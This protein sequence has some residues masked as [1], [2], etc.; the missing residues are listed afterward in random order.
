MNAALRVLAAGAVLAL[1]AVPAAAQSRVEEPGTIGLTAGGAYGMIT[2]QSRYG[3]D[4]TDGA[5]I[6]V[7]LRYVL[8]P[9][10]S[11]GATFA[12]QAYQAGTTAAAEGTDKVQMTNVLLDFYYYRDRNT[13]ASQYLVMGLGFY[14]PE[15][16][17]S[18]QEI[19]FPGENALLSVGAGAE[20]FIRE[21]WGLELSAR[22]LG[23]FGRGFTPQELADTTT[24]LTDSKVAL[25]LHAQVGLIYYL[26]R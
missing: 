1:A 11:T 10:W 12:S 17:D 21:N 13:D 9:H 6:T 25:G 3:R 7:G 5:G 14:R 23:Y 22:A 8:S 19:S 15:V 4:F 20:V 16:H 2:G 24:R 26:L 18:A